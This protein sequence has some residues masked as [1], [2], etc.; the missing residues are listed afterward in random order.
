MITKQGERVK[1]PI[2]LDKV[3]KGSTLERG[4]DGLSTTND[5]DP[6]GRLPGRER[7][8]QSS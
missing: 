3:V 5:A 2:I 6:W 1:G 8:E 4:E 7:Q